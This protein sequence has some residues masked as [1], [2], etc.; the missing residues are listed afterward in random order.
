MK[1]TP[2]QVFLIYLD[3]KKNGDSIMNINPIEFEPIVTD[4]FPIEK[5]EIF[6]IYSINIQNENEQ[7]KIFY[8]LNKEYTDNYTGYQKC[9][10]ILK[11]AIEHCLKSKFSFDIPI[12]QTLKTYLNGSIA[13]KLLEKAATKDI[14]ILDHVNSSPITTITNIIIRN[15]ETVLVEDY[16][17]LTIREFLVLPNLDNIWTC[18]EDED[19]L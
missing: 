18:I 1:L 14:T 9:I 7:E 8:F 4:W 5:H 17:E 16:R 13:L 15:Y 6:N 3:F 10:D 11:S 12:K 2:Q 19:M